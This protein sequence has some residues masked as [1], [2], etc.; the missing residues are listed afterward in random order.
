M[1]DAKHFNIIRVFLAH[2]EAKIF[3]QFHIYRIDFSMCTYRCI[4]RNSTPQK[5]ERK[6]IQVH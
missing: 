6:K 3:L 1:R 2:N 5:E 4:T